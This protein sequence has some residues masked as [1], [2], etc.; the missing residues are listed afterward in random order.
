MIPKKR[1]AKRLATTTITNELVDAISSIAQGGI[2]DVS[3]AQPWTAGRQVHLVQIKEPYKSIGGAYRGVVKTVAINR[4]EVFKNTTYFDKSKMLRDADY[5]GYHKESDSVKKRAVLVLN[6]AEAGDTTQLLKP[7]CYVLAE[8]AG[9]S[10][11]SIP[12]FIVSAFPRGKIT[13][14]TT[15]S[16][17]SEGSEAADTSTWSRTTNGT[18]LQIYIQTRTA[19]YDAGDEKLYGY[20]RL[21]TYDACG[22]LISVGAETR[23]EVDVPEAC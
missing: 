9:T 10:I 3:N 17:A 15:L 5:T 19:Y 18:P 23:V 20:F 2:C 6:M 7:D 16:A 13:S 22:L 8:D 4:S 1:E 11:D 14:P 21:F 12:M